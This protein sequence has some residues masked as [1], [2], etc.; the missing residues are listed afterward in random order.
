MTPFKSIRI[1]LVSILC[2]LMVA[3]A[4]LATGRLDSEFKD[5]SSDLATLVT[6]EL[7]PW[8]QDLATKFRI[9]S[10]IVPGHRLRVLDFLLDKQGA[11]Q[12]A[13]PQV[14]LEKQLYLV[15]RFAVKEN[16][17]SR[18]LNV[19]LEIVRPER[20]KGRKIVLH[21]G[22][23]EEDCIYHVELLVDSD[24]SLPS[25]ESV[26]PHGIDNSREGVINSPIVFKITKIT[27]Q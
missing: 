10:V 19:V 4:L 3:F 25:S 22:L 8:Q 16:L 14:T 7:P 23:L 9:H 18:V 1:V 17:G 11:P 26:E 13:I 20:L 2:L 21:G 24:T 6:S 27:A 15:T 12:P 5:E